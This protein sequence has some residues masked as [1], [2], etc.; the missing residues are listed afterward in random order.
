MGEA[1]IEKQRSRP[2]PSMEVM[3][4]TGALG[5]FKNG[6]CLCPLRAR[7]FMLKDLISS[8][9]G[10]SLYCRG[11]HGGTRQS[12]DLP[13]A[14]EL[15]SGSAGRDPS[16]SGFSCLPVPLSSCPSLPPSYPLW[17]WG[18]SLPR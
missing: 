16:L 7:S 10:P 17:V 1:G 3:W 18:P 12:S 13:G 11:G 9:S 8:S 6:L 14:A 5:T 4:K 2:S 15:V